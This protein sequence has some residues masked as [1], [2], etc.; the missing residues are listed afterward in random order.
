MAEK[1]QS[2]TVHPSI[3]VGR[4]FEAGRERLGMK[5]VTGETG[6]MRT[7]IEPMPHRPGLALSGFFK[8]FAWKRIQVVGMAEYE[9]LSSMSADLR[10]ERLAEVFAKKIP[11][12][13]F[14]RGKR[15]FPEAIELAKQ[16]GVSILQSNMVTRHFIHAATFALEDLHAPSCRVHGTMLEVAGVGVLIEGKAGL[17]KSETALGLIK[18][19]QALVAD[20]LTQLRRD[21]S[22][23]LL[24]SAMGHTRDYME[25]RGIGIIHVP[26]IFG[27]AAVRGEKQLDMV[28]TLKRQG[29]ADAELDRTGLDELQ[30]E[31]LGVKVPQLVIPVAP[32]RDLVNLVETA[33][34]EFK[35][36][37]SGVVAALNLTAQIKRHHDALRRADR[38]TKV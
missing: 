35:L 30:R 26:S 28:V 10:A 24:G 18:R 25:I 22:N 37:K 11:C 6:L 29:E 3:T 20:D 9:Y 7:I 17:G 33:A 31:F 38:G 16:H 12:M 13:V 21:S 36:R 4:F 32:G 19:G 27:V 14:T 1:R 23:C 5:L 8:H 34:Q 2:K 15:I